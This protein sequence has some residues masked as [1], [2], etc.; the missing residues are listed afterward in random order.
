MAPSGE[1]TRVF[2]RLSDGDGA[3]YERLLS[4][5][6]GELRSLAERYMR[7]ER[8]DHTL[9]STALVHEA[10]LKLVGRSPIHFENR[11]HFFGAAAQAM[12]QILVDHARK[13]R[14]QKRGRDWQRKHLDEVPLPSAASP[15]DLIALD[16]ALTRLDANDPRRARTIELRYF[17]GLSSEETAKIL[18]VTK[19]TVDRDCV[20]AQVWLHREMDRGYGRE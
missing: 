13:R 9:Q 10:Y 20:Y 16:D 6:Y 17:G 5:V 3:A 18:G 8:P 7:E 11:A 19:R 4:L 2:E 14:S 15:I 12:R 1:V